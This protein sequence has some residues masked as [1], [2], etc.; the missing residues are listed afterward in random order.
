MMQCLRGVFEEEYNNLSLWYFVS[1][2]CGIVVYF[3]LNF[4]P[5]F[6]VIFTIFLFSLLL[7]LTKKYGIFWQFSSGLVIAFAFGLLISKYRVLNLQGSIIGKPIITEVIGTIESIKPTIH[8]A[9]IVLNDIKIKK[10]NRNIKKVRISLP[11]KYLKEIIVSDKIGLLAKLYKPQGSILPG[12]YDF[13]FYA[14]LSEIGAN[15]YAMSPPKILLHN[16]KSTNSVI[17]KIRFDIYQNLV[18]KLG[19]IK[20]NFAAAILLGETKGIN[21]QLMQDMRQSGISHVL[22]VSGL[23]LSLVAMILF[24]SARFLLNLSN[25]LSYNYNIKL[26]AALCSLIGSFGYLELSSMQIAATRAFI[27]AAIFIYAIIIE[28][29]CFPL[30]SLAI[31]AFIILS[32]NP[33]YIFHP[34]FQLSFIA[35]LSLVAGYEFYLKN[36]WLLGNNKGIFSSIKF[37]MASNIYSSFLASIITAPV[38]INQ[39]FI[40]STYSIPNNLIVVPIMSFFLMPLALLSLPLM[41]LNID[42]FIL[43]IMGFFIDIIIYSAEYFNNLPAAVWYFGYI[44]N[45]SIILFLFGF[46]WICIWKTKWRLWGLMIMGVSFILML[47]SPKPDLI[48]DAGANAVG[49][50]NKDN[51]LEI[52]ADKMP[53]FNR[54]YW[55]NWF[56]QKDSP[57]S[58][59]TNN[60]FITNQ[61]YKVIINYENLSK[62]KKCEEAEIYINLLTNTKCR[63]SLVTINKAFLNSASVVLIFCNSTKCQIRTGN[64]SNRFK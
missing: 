52:Y 35:V 40:F 49:I 39:F 26:I 8:G 20:G 34:S 60:I 61:G 2:I 27:M 25:Y 53:T 54:Q 41:W 50:K 3:S 47:Y 4:E 48:F 59:L 55:A 7:L 1:F 6:L 43:K 36:Q 19:S 62:N 31:A 28:R 51:Q 64:I 10:I 23:H 13:G 57:V 9:Q 56:G 14:Y 5:S 44:T 37:Y 33:E 30:R 45:L 11:R 12:G 38:V 29:S 46:F 18:E 21:R 17:Y 15:G 22:C 24:I 42:G 63:G 58:P 32:L 16:D